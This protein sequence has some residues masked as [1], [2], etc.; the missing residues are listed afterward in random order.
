MM[1]WWSIPLNAISLV[2]LVMVSVHVC[3]LHVCKC[4]LINVVN[5]VNFACRPL[6]LA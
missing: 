2:N 5:F 6:E 3:G 4:I 1:Y